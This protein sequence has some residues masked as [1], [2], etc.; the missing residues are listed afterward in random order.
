MDTNE[1]WIAICEPPPKCSRCSCEIRVGTFHYYGHNTLSY[2]SAKCVIADK[3]A[4]VGAML[5]TSQERQ[6]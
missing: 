1:D 6:R 2:C 4:I 3:Q 5:V